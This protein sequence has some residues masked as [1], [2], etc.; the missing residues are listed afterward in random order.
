MKNKNPKIIEYFYTLSICVMVK[1]GFFKDTLTF[2][3]FYGKISVYKGTKKDKIYDEIIRMTKSNLKERCDYEGN[4]AVIS[5]HL[6]K[7]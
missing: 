4:F 2:K 7:N 3:S 5:Y 1:R 6:S